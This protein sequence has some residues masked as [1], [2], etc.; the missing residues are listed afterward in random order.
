MLAGL[1]RR[2]PLP[3]SGAIALVT[4]LAV[5]PSDGRAACGGYVTVVAATDPHG[6]PAPPPPGP[7]P[8]PP[9]LP[10]AR[11]P[12]SPD[13]G[14]PGVGPEDGRTADARRGHHLRP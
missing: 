4:A 2:V 14:R 10:R 6:T 11:L 5:C 8:P 7:P 3:V 12:P 9:P 13:P 1:Y